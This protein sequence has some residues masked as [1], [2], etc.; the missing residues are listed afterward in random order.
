MHRVLAVDDSEMNL[1]LVAKALRASGFEVETALE[2]AAALEMMRR[3]LPDLLITD[4]MMPGMSGCE[5]ARSVHHTLAAALPILVITAC[6]LDS[7]AQRFDVPIAGY[8]S[9][10]FHIKALIKQVKSLLS[11]E[12]NCRSSPFFQDYN[13]FTWTIDAV[14]SE[15]V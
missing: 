2:G 6:D 7:V 5:L 3:S 8:I 10:P 4:V 1:L 12:P 15:R 11:T 14:P 13:G 9:K